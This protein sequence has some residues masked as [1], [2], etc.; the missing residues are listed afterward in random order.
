MNG[1]EI[2]E[3]L[4]RSAG[5]ARDD[6]F[7]EHVKAKHYP[8]IQW[9]EIHTKHGPHSASVFVMD[10]AL[11]LGDDL[12]SFRITPSAVAAQQIVDVLSEHVDDAR[13]V[14]ML[15]T[16][17]VDAIF[18]QAGHVVSPQT[19]TH[20]NTARGLA[21]ILSRDPEA[22]DLP[23]NSTA[24][25]L[26]HSLEVDEEIEAH[27]GLIAEVGKS[28]VLTNRLASKTHKSANYGMHRGGGRMCAEIETPWRNRPSLVRGELAEPSL[29]LINLRL[30]QRGLPVRHPRRESE[31]G[32]E[33]PK[34]ES[35]SIGRG[36][37]DVVGPKIPD[38]EGHTPEREV[39]VIVV[40]QI[41]GPS[42]QGRH[43]R[44]HHTSHR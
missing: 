20:K 30:S 37:L 6:A 1:Q 35:D 5:Q 31:A 23:M 9:T 4:P 36:I 8:S 43:R 15:T 3:S 22:V 12:D 25:M 16:K 29:E 14:T 28:F 38:V 42:F 27:C 18:E 13:G 11:R 7:V 10:D 21:A 34:V 40:C 41:L 26:R 19:Q 32:P 33:E 17:L 44:D 24:R 39:L 2:F